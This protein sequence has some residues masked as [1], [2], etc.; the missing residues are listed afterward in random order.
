MRHYFTVLIAFLSL[1]HN[2]L[3]QNIQTDQLKW[4]PASKGT[5]F[6]LHA[7]LITNGIVAG[8]AQGRT[9]VSENNKWGRRARHPNGNEY[10][11]NPDSSWRNANGSSWFAA[12]F[13][14][15][16]RDEWHLNQ[17]ITTV[18]TT[19]QMGIVAILSIDDFKKHKKPKWGKLLLY[20]LEA[21]AARLLTKRAVL[22]YYDVF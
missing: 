5:R 16:L 19:A 6:L 11:W 9:Q 20:L 15:F 21:N 12:N 18:T 10:W 8:V 4:K 14:P 17:T 13:T 7:S 3:S 2:G 22:A 1:F